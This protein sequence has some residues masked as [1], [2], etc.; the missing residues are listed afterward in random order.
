[1]KTTFLLVQIN[2]MLERTKSG[3]E[4][5][6]DCDEQAEMSD[7]ETDL[8]SVQNKM[9]ELNAMKVSFRSLWLLQGSGW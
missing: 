3:D 9:E 7:T 1:M 6:D 4:E 5:D 8:Q 2:S